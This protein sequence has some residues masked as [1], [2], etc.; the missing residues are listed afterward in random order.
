MDTRFQLLRI[1]DTKM[2]EIANFLTDIF[3]QYPLNVET[4][5][6]IDNARKIL[7]SQIYVEVQYYLQKEDAF[8]IQDDD[9]S[10]GGILL[11]MNYLRTKAL[12]LALMEYKV[13]RQIRKVAL[14][15]D[16]HILE[17]N[18]HVTNQILDTNW[19][20][21]I[22]GGNYY[23]IKYL[24][25]SEKYRGLGI[26]SFLLKNI[27]DMCGEKEIPIIVQSHNKESVPVYLKNGFEVVKIFENEQTEVKQWCLVKR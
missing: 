2:D 20:H 5:K 12:R 24:A 15:K 18:C 6:G 19:Q 21:G 4:L 22:S 16:I 3:I 1:P 17:K 27:I 11:G 10:I 14:K 13:H 8:M 25:V 7:W 26:G 9:G 23:Y